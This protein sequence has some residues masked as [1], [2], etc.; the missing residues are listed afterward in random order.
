MKIDTKITLLEIAMK[1]CDIAI[2][3][4]IMWMFVDSYQSYIEG[5]KLISIVYSGFGLY[6][7]FYLLS[8]MIKQ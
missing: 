7:S 1:L 3:I 4:F 8:D 6:M 2:S 5:E